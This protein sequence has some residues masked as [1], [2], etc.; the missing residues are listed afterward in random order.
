MPEAQQDP[1]RETKSE[2]R[3][4]GWRLR[5]RD[6][7]AITLIALSIAWI[8]LAVGSP[9]T[10]RTTF[11]SSTILSTFAP[12][13]AA[14]PNDIPITQYCNADTIDGVQPTRVRVV[15][16]L[17]DGQVETFDPYQVG[18]TVTTLS[19][20]AGVFDP[21]TFLPFTTL[22]LRVAPAYE[23]VLELVVVLLG[24]ILWV[25]RLGMSTAAGVVG[26]FV[27]GLSGF[28]VTWTNWPQ[29]SV[30]CW[31]PMLFWGAERLAQRRDTSSALLV[32]LPFGS[33][34]LGGFPAVTG[35]SLYAVSVYLVIRLLAQ[36]G[37]L[38]ALGGGILAG[39]A[40][41][42]LGAGLSAFM[43]VPFTLTYK[44]HGFSYRDKLGTAVLNHQAVAT[45]L[46]PNGF[47]GCGYRRGTSW[48][49]QRGYVESD[50]YIGTAALVLCIVGLSGRLRRGVPLGPRVFAVGLAAFVLNQMAV[51]DGL[52]RFVSTLPVFENSPPGR[53]RA[54]F[55]I[56]FAL[57]A[58]MGADRIV[59]RSWQPTWWRRWQTLPV[60][61]LWVA[62]GLVALYVARQTHRIE[63]QHRATHLTRGVEDALVVAAVTAALV[64]LAATFRRL[65]L[66]VMLA[67]ALIVGVQGAAYARGFWP[68]N[69]NSTY[70]PVTPT[71]TYLNAHL[72]TYRVAGNRGA[73]R[74]GTATFYGSAS[75]VGH[76]LVQADWNDLLRSVTP[77]ADATATFTALALDDH[78][79]QSP[80]LDLMSVRY[81]VGT[82][83]DL[84]LGTTV[85]AAAADGAAP[86]T[87]TSP[88]TVPVG[89]TPLRAVAVTFASPLSVAGAPFAALHADVLDA[90]GRVVGSGTHRIYAGLAAGS[91]YTVGLTDPG[92]APGPYS[93]RIGIEDDA[94]ATSVRTHGGIPALTLTTRPDDGLRLV[95]AD[96]AL[97]Y[98]RTTAL[99]HVRWAST[100]KVVPAAQQVALLAAG[101]P[102]ASVVVPPG[103]PGSG[104]GSAASVTVRTDDGTAVR[105]QVDAQGA[106]YLVVSNSYLQGWSA[107]VDG[108]HAPLVD[109]DHGMLAVPVPAG[110][111]D[112]AL[113][114]EAPGLDVGIVITLVSLVVYAVLW[115]DVARRRRRRAGAVEP[116]S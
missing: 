87:A 27:F 45:A 110:S 32:A 51:R 111:H 30:A 36:P 105:A 42:A 15:D 18:G 61:A 46:F 39:G 13:R 56:S 89:S 48:I 113:R 73:M 41:V 65:A 81:I 74:P 29:T 2:R 64:L 37:R 72:G 100:A 96:G 22:P 98:E 9:L 88:L 101:I 86:F 17:R 21:V 8:V 68:R 107:T 95:S 12:W 94:H 16:A 104:S 49:L 20:D 26:G 106:G 103:S 1:A 14:A 10:G 109:A 7:L 3:G 44:D 63:F 28:M 40:G 84:L 102:A 62:A 25:R 54:I 82:E 47:G 91:N 50:M 55:A 112:V 19:Q 71:Q 43:L 114:Y 57:L 24:M 75:P 58:A 60:A 35:W 33:M 99:P 4:R 6:P 90:Q 52:S 66:P 59:S 108:R 23:K 53:L 97:L 67:V 31:I 85:P 70:Y 115:A 79:I 78:S 34:I 116:E 69:P 76:A 92:S 83:D 77:T 80:V 38:R 93:I 11:Q 5:A